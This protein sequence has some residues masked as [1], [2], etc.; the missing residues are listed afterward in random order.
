MLSE[1]PLVQYFGP[2]HARKEHEVQI[3]TP[4]GQ[5][6]GLCQEAIEVGDAGTMMHFVQT[7]E[8]QRAIG[9]LRPVH[10]ECSMR[11]VIGSVAH[12]EGRCSCVVPDATEGDPPGLSAREAARAAVQAWHAMRS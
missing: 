4:L 5:L 10:Y 3:A 11:A 2:P 1:P 9:Q 12:L 7:D 6:C 8:E